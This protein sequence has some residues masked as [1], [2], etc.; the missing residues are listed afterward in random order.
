MSLEDLMEVEVFSVSKKKQHKKNIPAA[1]Y[2]IEKEDII[3]SGATNIP[4]ILRMAPGIQVLRISNNRWAISI[5]GAAREYS[6]KLLVMIDGRSVYSPTFSGVFWETLDIPIETIERVEIIRGPGSSIWGANAV[7]GVI[8]IITENAQKMQG[9]VF[10]VSCGDTLRAATVLSYGWKKNENTFVRAHVKAMNSAQTKIPGPDRGE[11]ALKNFSAG[12]RL[13]QEKYSQTFCLTGNIYSSSADDIATMFNEPP[14]AVPTLFTQKIQG[15]NLSA[16]WQI[17]HFSGDKTTV[18]FSL[19][20]SYLQHILVDEER[21][22]F[23]FEYN[24]H[25]NARKNHEFIFGLSGRLSQDKISSS[26]YMWVDNARR[27]TSQYRFFLT[28]EIT[29]VPNRLSL[30]LSS[31]LEHNQYTGFEFQPSMRLSYNPDTKNCLWLSLSRA[32]RTPSR[33]ERGAGYF[34]NAFPLAVPPYSIKTDLRDFGSEKVDALEFGWRRKI[35]PDLSFDLTAFYNKY[36]DLAGSFV[37]QNI[38]MPGYLLVSAGIDNLVKAEIR[39]AEINFDWQANR[40]FKISGNYSYLNIDTSCPANVFLADV[41]Q[42]FPEHSATLRTMLNLTPDLQWD[43]FAHYRSDIEFGNFRGAYSLDSQISWKIAAGKK[44]SLV[45]QNVFDSNH[46]D[47][48]PEV[49]QSTIR[50]HQRRT[51]LKFDWTY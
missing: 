42:N 43:N 12:F 39:G 38:F 46:K 49:I 48:L 1:V 35:N 3:R 34:E 14:S 21:S 2:L 44:L 10:S 8:N 7:N 15:L 50:P 30:T 36:R 47:F 13:D 27:L 28:D 18:Q 31:M 29:L 26:K 20:Q 40:N 24:R 9:T 51:Y 5:R 4:E 6:N 41:N 33:L 32:K 45:C 23:D 19:E 11:D 22:T 16:N 37:Q 25:K 17:D